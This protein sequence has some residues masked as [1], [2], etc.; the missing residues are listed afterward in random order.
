ESTITLDVVDGKP[1]RGHPDPKADPKKIRERWND[2]GIG[3]LLQRDFR[4][5]TDAFRKASE[6]TPDWPEAYVNVGRTRMAEGNLT[7]A[8]S[9]FEKA[10]HLY[11]A[12]T[13]PL[14]KPMVPYLR[15]R[16]QNFYAQALFGSSRL[17]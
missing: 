2:Y 3:F 13:V 8:I 1:D 15:A 5:A 4:R 9:A 11:D 17:D 12:P 7:E 16:T 14:P 10:L 6:I